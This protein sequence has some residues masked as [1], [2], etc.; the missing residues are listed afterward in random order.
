MNP[1]RWSRC[2]K[3]IAF[4]YGCL[5]ETRSVGWNKGAGYMHAWRMY[6]LVF[7]FQVMF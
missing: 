6:A 2:V 1:I 5:V 3:I 4:E 7:L